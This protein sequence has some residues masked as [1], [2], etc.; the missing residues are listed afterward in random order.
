[1]L[2]SALL[3][4]VELLAL[5][6]ESITIL[7]EAVL[8]AQLVQ[9]TLSPLLV[10]NPAV[11]VQLD[12]L[13]T[14]VECVLDAQRVKNPTQGAL[15]AWLAPQVSTTLTAVALLNLINASVATV[16]RKQMLE[17]QLAVI[18]Q[19]VRT[20]LGLA[21]LCVFLLTAPRVLLA[22]MVDILLLA[23]SVAHLALVVLRKL[24]PELAAKSAL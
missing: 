5:S 8:L 14:E 12:R 2:A 21:L 16:E 15:V 18:V 11:S 19:L 4:M 3:D 7:L 1:M 13:R 23:P 10:L 20:L 17:R 22:Q 24:L 9:L 6:A